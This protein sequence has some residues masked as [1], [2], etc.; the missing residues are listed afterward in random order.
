[1]QPVTNA[2]IAAVV[3]GKVLTPDEVG[4]GALVLLGAALASTA[5]EREGAAAEEG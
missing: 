5:S 4:G 2:A 1:M 3:L